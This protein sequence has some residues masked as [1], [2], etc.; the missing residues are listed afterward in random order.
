LVLGCDC[1][2]YP[3]LFDFCLGNGYSVSVALIIQLEEG[4]FCRENST[5]NKFW[6]YADDTTSDLG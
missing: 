1:Y 6:G 3:A 4:V 2:V 5:S